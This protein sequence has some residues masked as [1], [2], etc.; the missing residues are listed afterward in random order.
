MTV[1]QDLAQV[2]IP[3]TGSR[4]CR[5]PRFGQGFVEPDCLPFK[6]AAS[7]SGEHVSIL[8]TR[9]ETHRPCRRRAWP[10]GRRS[11][12]AVAPADQLAPPAVADGLLRVSINL[13]LRAA[14]EA[15]S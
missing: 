1:G 7:I 4:M 9:C 13:E 12:W 2:V 5:P 11:H 10:A 14:S 15:S 3:P 6:D 8:A